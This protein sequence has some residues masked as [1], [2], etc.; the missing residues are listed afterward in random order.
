MKKFELNN[1]NTLMF[2]KLDKI[3]KTPNSEAIKK[4]KPIFEFK[5]R[6]KDG[7]L[8]SL[9]REKKLEIKAVNEYY[10]S[11]LS[12]QSSFYNLRQW[13]KEFEQSQQFKKNICEFP[14]IDFHKTKRISGEGEF[15]A[16]NK[17]YNNSSISNNPSN[18]LRTI[19]FK[20]M[21]ILQN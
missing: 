19:K 12:R 4:L 2:N 5:K 15:N 10:K 14:S 3:N 16:I 1:V 9:T 17:D 20:K 21:K 6:T 7:S 18:Y 13:N 8:T 11:K